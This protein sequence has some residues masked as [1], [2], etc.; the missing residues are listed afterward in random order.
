[1]AD[2]FRVGPYPDGGGLGGG[3]VAAGTDEDA[4]GAVVGIV[5]TREL[6]AGVATGS[7]IDS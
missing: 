2:A 5:T 1:V 3:V 7:H 4:A 6:A